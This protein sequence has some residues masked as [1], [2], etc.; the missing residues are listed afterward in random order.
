MAEPGAGQ[1]GAVDAGHAPGLHVQQPHRDEAQ[2]QRLAAATQAHVIICGYGRSGQNLARL[3]EAEGIPYMA[4]D[5]D[6]DP[7]CSATPRGCKA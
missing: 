1:H 6:P 3:L 2:Q 7:W 5:L 4:L